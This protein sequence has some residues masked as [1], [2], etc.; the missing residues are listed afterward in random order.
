MAGQPD[1]PGTPAAQWSWDKRIP[2]ALV[3]T[4]GIQT[5]GMV[6]WAASLTSRVTNLETALAASTGQDGRI[7]RVETKLEGVSDDLGRIEEKV[8][9]LIDRSQPASAGR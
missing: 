4:V 8:D 9:R 3:L 1:G 6:W 7:I 2:I 5:A